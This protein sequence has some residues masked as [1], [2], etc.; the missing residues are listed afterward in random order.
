MKFN[1]KQ[2]R[3]HT[4]EMTQNQILL[5]GG[6]GGQIAKLKLTVNRHRTYALA[7]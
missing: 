5:Y 4:K 2:R 3:L 1:N 6:E 7:E